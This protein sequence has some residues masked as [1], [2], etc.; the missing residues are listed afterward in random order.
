MAKRRGQLH[1]M[2]LPSNGYDF[3]EPYTTV[4]CV[5]SLLEHAKVTL[6]YDI[7]T[8]YDICRMKRDIERPMY[9]NLNRRLAQ[10]IIDGSLR[11]DGV[12]NVGITE[13]QTNLDSYQCIHSYLQLHANHLCRESLLLKQGTLSMYDLLLRTRA[14]MRC[15]ELLYRNGRT[16]FCAATLMHAQ[17]FFDTAANYALFRVAD[18]FV[19]NDDERMRA[20]EQDSKTGRILPEMFA[21]GCATRGKLL[22]QFEAD[23]WRCWNT[24]HNQAS[25]K[26]GGMTLAE[27]GALHPVFPAVIESS[28][29][30]GFKKGLY[31]RFFKAMRS[32]TQAVTPVAKAA[33]AKLR[34][35]KG[36]APGTKFFYVGK[37]CRTMQEMLDYMDGSAAVIGDF[38]VPLLM[39][40]PK[41]TDF[42]SDTAFSAAVKAVEQARS[43]ALPHAQSLGNAFQITNFLR[44]IDEDVRFWIEMLWAMS[45]SGN[46]RPA[47]GVSP[48]SVANALRRFC[49]AP[50]STGAPSSAT[51]DNGNLAVGAFDAWVAGP[52]VGTTAS[53]EITPGA[54]SDTFHTAVQPTSVWIQLPVCGGT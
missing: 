17:C 2:V 1:D 33:V 53:S 54:D 52:G 14:Y 44:D 37:V 23:F 10:I 8:L 16:Y 29:R 45:A 35:S 34:G 4:L 32:D 26:G 41:R 49:S 3:G 30:V 39:P 47:P 40:M 48:A 31:E 11:S 20:S 15:A 13:F 12:L 51:P 25:G 7:E 43:K 22:D 42:D 36:C 21:E 5:H 46:A 18:D 38:M 50:L 6:I 24:A 28:L 19:D 27:M 9:T